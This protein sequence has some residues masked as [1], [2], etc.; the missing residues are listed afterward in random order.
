V[1][2]ERWATSASA[3]EV[4]SSSLNPGYAEQ[5]RYSVALSTQPALHRV[6]VDVISMF[7]KIF[8]VTNSMIRK[9]SLPNFP[10]SE[11][12]AECMRGSTLDQLNGSLQ[13][14]VVRRRQQQ[15]YVFGHRHKSMQLEFSLPSIAVHCLQEEPHIRFH[16]EVPSALRSRERYEICSWWGHQ[17]SRL[18]STSQ[19]LKPQ[20]L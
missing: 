12:K 5:Y 13:R 11:F 9:S 18:H 2:Q 17:T 7:G 10:A 1:P 6:L 16:D 20:C 15:V 19:R 8:S 3:A 14:D 4:G